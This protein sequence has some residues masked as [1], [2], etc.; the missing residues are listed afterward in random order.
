MIL[1]LWKQFQPRMIIAFTVKNFFT[2]EKYC[3]KLTIFVIFLLKE[4]NIPSLSVAVTETVSASLGKFLMWYFPPVPNNLLDINLLDICISF[5]YYDLYLQCFIVLRLISYMAF[6]STIE[7]ES[8][9]KIKIN[10]K[11]GMKIPKLPI[12]L[13]D[14]LITS[15]WKNVPKNWRRETKILTY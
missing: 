5:E 7:L 12:S 14:L 1:L 9:M 11:G 3:Q 13:S 2:S 4:K 8:N 6:M 10:E 15:L